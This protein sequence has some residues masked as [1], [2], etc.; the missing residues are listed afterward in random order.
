MTSR[1]ALTVS[2]PR[3]ECSERVTDL[4]KRVRQA[5][6][7]ARFER[8]EVHAFGS[9]VNGFGDET[10]DIDLVLDVPEEILEQIVPWSY[11]RDL[12]PATLDYLSDYLVQEGFQV[13]EKVLSAKVPILKLTIDGVECDL[14][15][16]NL[17]PVF[18][19]KLLSLYAEKDPRVVEMARRV[20]TWA[21]KEGVHGA[22]NGHLSSYTFN[23][24][25]IFYMQQKG[26]L[27]CLQTNADNHPQW[28]GERS[29][30]KA[31]NVFIDEA[32]RA[33]TELQH[34][35]DA[36]TLRR[37]AQFL[38]DDKDFSWGRDVIS[39]RQ[40]KV[41]PI[42]SMCFRE[43]NRRLRDWDDNLLH[44]E[45]PFDISRNLSCVF[46]PGSNR[47]LWNAVRRLAKEPGAAT[48]VSYPAG[49][50]QSEPSRVAGNSMAFQ[51]PTKAG[52]REDP[53]ETET[54]PPAN[55]FLMRNHTDD[56]ASTARYPAPSGPAQPAAFAPENVNPGTFSSALMW[57][58][59]GLRQKEEE[60]APLKKQSRTSRISS[61]KSGSLAKV[62]KWST[63]PLAKGERLRF[64]GHFQKKT[65]HVGQSCTSPTKLLEELLAGSG[66]SL[67]FARAKDLTGTRFPRLVAAPDVLRRACKSTAVP[68]D[69]D[70]LGAVPEA[71]PRGELQRLYWAAADIL[72]ADAHFE[73]SGSVDPDWQVTVADTM[74]GGPEVSDAGLPPLPVD[75]G[76]GAPLPS[77]TAPV[78][79]APVWQV[80]SIELR[81]IRFRGLC[82]LLVRLA[83]IGLCRQLT[84]SWDGLACAVLGL[85]GGLGLDFVV[86]SSGYFVVSA[87][88]GLC[89]LAA[90]QWARLS[91]LLFAVA[92]A[93]GAVNEGRLKAAQLPFEAG[94]IVI[95]EL[96]SSVA[97]ED[98]GSTL[99]ERSSRMAAMRAK[100]GAW[101]SS[102]QGFTHHS[103]NS[104][105]F[106][107]RRKL[108]EVPFGY[109]P[110]ADPL[111]CYEQAQHQ[112]VLSN[113]NACQGNPRHLTPR[114]VFCNCSGAHPAAE[115]F[116]RSGELEGYCLVAENARADG[117]VAEYAL[118]VASSI[119]APERWEQLL[120]WGN[121][122]RV[123][124]VKLR[125]VRCTGASRGLTDAEFLIPDGIHFK[126]N[127]RVPQGC[128]LDMQEVQQMSHAT[129]PSMLR[130]GNFMWVHL[131]P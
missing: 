68:A 119:F 16:N 129:K 54:S 81:G 46:S 32:P 85:C 1:S 39:I 82:A 74:A 75:G 88:S 98:D 93:P 78:D 36:A 26:G 11:L 127:Q 65:T 67:Q 117:V 35:R 55:F 52:R 83:P 4:K 130:V 87:G 123:S 33:E 60:E 57:L 114:Q 30:R 79:P 27:P 63:A 5:A 64:E 43:L 77:N 90:F 28:Y 131:V 69:T 91:G 3:I 72:E 113:N 47:R 6:L 112:P 126:F 76:T 8:V 107:S 71:T 102:D 38:T 25:V 31:W 29:G 12:V 128:P 2:V 48:L 97:G 17:L 124:S 115:N 53:A 73:T 96:R 44:I 125:R 51:G 49:H 94:T 70:T 23:L 105:R 62:K 56:P 108:L 103:G 24:M 109:K 120:C 66:G 19:T 121:T 15:C 101:P 40:G 99:M 10:S 9:S 110:F 111:G 84:S 61:Q 7:R 104:K 100:L 42:D 37:F 92:N 22:T 106:T 45:D 122:G 50:F 41:L 58:D 18:N 80:C 14:S 86:A 20:K 21:K 95:A 89:A 59:E 118:L 13:R 116:A 34:H